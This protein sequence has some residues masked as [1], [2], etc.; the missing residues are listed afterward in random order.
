M[1]PDW[2]AGRAITSE[3]QCTSNQ[4]LP[5]HEIIRLP[6]VQRVPAF[7]P[8]ETQGKIWPL[9]RFFASFGLCRI[10]QFL[11]HPTSQCTLFFIYF[12]ESSTGYLLFGNMSLFLPFLILVEFYLGHQFFHFLFW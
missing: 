11:R 4:A 2:Y 5:Y 1:V 6:S 8:N 10:V 12:A 3:D 9:Y 7:R